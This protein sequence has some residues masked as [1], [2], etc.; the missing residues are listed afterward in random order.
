MASRYRLQPTAEQTA[1]MAMHCSHAR[2]VWNLCLEQTN[3]YRPQWGATP[4]KYEQKRQLTEAR[5]DSFLGEGSSVVQQQAL[6]DFDQAM[7]NWW[8]GTHGRPTWRR[9]GIHEAFAIRDLTVRKLNRHW[10]EVLVPK[11]GLVKFRLSRP[12]PPEAKSARV[13][14]DRAGRWHVS[15]TAPQPTFNREATGESVG[16]DVGIAHTLTLST[17]EHLDMPALLTPGK[18]QRKRRLQRQMAR[19]RKGSNRRDRTKAKVANLAAREADR[20]NDWI[21]KTSTDLVRRFDR[22]ALEDLKIVSMVRSASGTIEA[23]GVNVAQKRGLN[24]AIHAQAWGK[25]RKR[26]EDK[27]SA[28]TS[29]C[30]VEVVNP[31]NTSR[32]CS[33]CGH[34]ENGNRKNQ[35]TF[36]CVSCGHSEHAD[37]NASKNIKCKTAVGSTVTGRGGTP[38]YRP[39]KTSTVSAQLA[40]SG[41]S[42]RNPLALAMGN[43]NCCTS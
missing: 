41:A 34:T 42:A 17:G 12:V 21:E 18:A 15:F 23:P 11:C 24:R 32:R 33:E 26:C 22:I 31:R 37:V 40:L 39:D 2:F 43:F 3:M 13:T 10:A 14:L 30:V 16:V 27:A 1:V 35:A 20:R 8:G 9:H 4:N 36:Q 25:L 7:R 38:E 29:L 28:A 5:K 19:Q 6:R